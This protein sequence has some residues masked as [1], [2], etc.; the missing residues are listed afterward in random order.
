MESLPVVPAA[1]NL[2]LDG[3]RAQRD[4]WAVVGR[5]A[6]M[7]ER[8]RRRVAVQL[9]PDADVDTVT[10]MLAVERRC[11]PFFGLDWDPEQRLLRVAVADA[12][13]EPA[14]DAIAYAL[15]LE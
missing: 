10:E 2:D 12:K 3:L 8:Q 11:C 15:G 4:R 6:R 1:C 13:H 5:G 9:A 14:L 7:V